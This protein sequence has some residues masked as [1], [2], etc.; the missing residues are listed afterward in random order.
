MGLFTKDISTLN[1]AFVHVLQTTYYAEKQIVEALPTMIEKA[2]SPELKQGFE[3]HLRETKNHVTH[4][5]QVFRQHG[6]DAEEA[7]CPAIDGILKAGSGM[8]GNIADPH[9]LDAA[10]IA[11]AQMVEHYEMAQYGTLAA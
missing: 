5:E 8:T 3:T 2:K 11:G 1:D 7:T 6:V 9:V 10:L 4:L